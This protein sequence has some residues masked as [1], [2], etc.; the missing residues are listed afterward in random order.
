MDLFNNEDLDL[1]RE[2]LEDADILTYVTEEYQ[3]EKIEID[4]FEKLINHVNNPFYKYHI[5]SLSI[6]ESLNGGK[7]L[8]KLFF[9]EVIR[10]AKSKKEKNMNI[11][12]VG[13]ESKWN[14]N[15]TTDN[16]D[17]Y[18]GLDNEVRFLSEEY[19]KYLTT[20][21]KISKADFRNRK[22][23][24]FLIKKM[25]EYSRN[26][27][28]NTIINNLY[29][30]INQQINKSYIHL[31][32]ED[33]FLLGLLI[34]DYAE[35]VSY[36][37]A[38]NKLNSQDYRSLAQNLLKH[39]SYYL[40]FDLLKRILRKGF[41]HLLNL[42]RDYLK[43]KIQYDSIIEDR[44]GFN[45]NRENGEDIVFYYD[46]LTEDEDISSV[47]PMDLFAEKNIGD[48][49]YLLENVGKDDISQ[50]EIIEFLEKLS[51]EFNAPLAATL[52]LNNLNKRNEFIHTIVPR[53]KK[54]FGINEMTINEKSCSITITPLNLVSLSVKYEH[55]FTFNR[56]DDTHT[57]W[58]SIYD[59]TKG[60]VKHL[61]IGLTIA[62]KLLNAI[63]LVISKDYI[64]VVNNMVIH[65]EI[66]NTFSFHYNVINIV[67]H[68]Y[69]NLDIRQNF[70]INK[71]NKFAPI[72][73][74]D[75][76]ST[77]QSVNFKALPSY[78]AYT[79]FIMQNIMS[80]KNN[81]Y[82]RYSK[83]ELDAEISFLVKKES[84]LKNKS[85]FKE[86]KV[87]GENR[88]FVY[89]ALEILQGADNLGLYS[90]DLTPEVAIKVIIG[91]SVYELTS[92]TGIK[93]ANIFNSFFE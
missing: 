92:S 45:V 41:N 51:K 78:E 75:I 76:I 80:I 82:L 64:S 60:S 73:F 14:I 21:Q 43:S 91:Q 17:N 71:D 39:G 63:G 72:N 24:I 70:Y 77:Y 10:N 57:N 55:F 52:V 85:S 81:P 32:K 23:L 61:D 90:L 59:A 58:L 19:L 33:F 12:V 25:K 79:K 4:M 89:E 65:S 38:I 30:E 44:M 88:S 74:K 62:H 66:E 40:V 54:S 56:L 27:D 20:Y 68:C 46:E 6:Y 26:G 34:D 3:D 69:S 15:P 22:G 13:Q 29:D 50:Q 53:I 11:R 5:E 87:I 47:K 35:K 49:I 2:L 16:N 37:S 86:L 18:S 8:I 93:L 7:E 28:I 1:I 67:N 36:G 42:E 83:Q 84:Y 31:F 48:Y 9:S